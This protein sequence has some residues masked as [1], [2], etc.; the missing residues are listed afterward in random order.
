MCKDNVT[1]DEGCCKQRKGEF[2]L[3]ILAWL[4]ELQ[5]LLLT[6]DRDL[7]PWFP[8]SQAF[9]F[10][11]ELITG[12]PGSPADR[13]QIMGLLRLNHH[14]RQFCIINLSTSVCLS[15]YENTLEISWIQFQVTTRKRLLQ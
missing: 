5:G 10:R 1:K 12:F 7:Y 9:G 6:L 11:L 8:G 13:W 2:P 4:F 14:V 3:L 15:V